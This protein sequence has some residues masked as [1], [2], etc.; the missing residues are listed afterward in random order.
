MMKQGAES[1]VSYPVLELA[2]NG[3]LKAKGWERIGLID[4]KVGLLK[5]PRIR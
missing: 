2:K 4:G 3:I 5:V 1:G